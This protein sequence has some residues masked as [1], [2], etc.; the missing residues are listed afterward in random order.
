MDAELNPHISYY[1][2]DNGDL[3]YAHWT[4]QKWEIQSVETAGDVGQ[5]TSLA[6]DEQGQ[7]HISYYDASLGDLKYAF[8]DGKSWV[9]FTVDSPGNVGKF[10]SLALDPVGRPCISYYD[11]TSGDLK[12]AQGI[13]G[14]ERLYF[15]LMAKSTGGIGNPQQ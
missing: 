14:S 1:D 10:S 6:L 15:P 7:P 13:F 5:Y 8:W 9:I 12:Y 11:E 3:K 4:G 2:Q